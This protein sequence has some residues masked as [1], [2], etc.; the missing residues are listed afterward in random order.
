MENYKKHMKFK[1]YLPAIVFFRFKDL[2]HL[3]LR[4]HGSPFDY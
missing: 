4:L 3:K 2:K 1:L